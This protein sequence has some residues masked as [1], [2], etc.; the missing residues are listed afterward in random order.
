M[1][2]TP[3]YRVWHNIEKRF[4]DLRSISFENEEIVYDA[5]GEGNYYD[6]SPF[7]D[8][9]FQQYT[10]LKDSKGVEIY[11][12]DIVKYTIKPN[13][14]NFDIANKD[15]FAD[16]VWH[17]HTSSFGCITKCKDTDLSEDTFCSFGDLIRHME[18][19]E[20]VGNIFEKSKELFQ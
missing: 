13:H 16:V 3:N 6:T 17:E 4:V 9:V 11:E 5:Q 2:R 20:V 12:G 18:S 14:L 7:R 1:N 19:F 10:G 8:V 15:F